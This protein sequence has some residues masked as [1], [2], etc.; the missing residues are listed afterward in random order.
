MVAVE[1][2]ESSVSCRACVAGILPLDACV[3]LD[4][5]KTGEERCS[6]LASDTHNVAVLVQAVHRVA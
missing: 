2:H 1:L 6:G 5:Q 3:A 4:Q